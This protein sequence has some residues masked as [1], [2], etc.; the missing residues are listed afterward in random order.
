MAQKTGT[1]GVA[2]LLANLNTIGGVNSFSVDQIAQIIA[3]DNLNY[4]ALVTEAI[5]DLAETTEDQVRGSGGSAGGDMMEVDEFSRGPT[6]KD[7]PGYLIGFPLRKYQ[8]PLGWT[9]Q[10]ER[11]AT[12][13]DVAMKN[14]AAQAADMRRTRYEIQKAIF[15]PT[16]YSFRD[17]LVNKAITAL[18]VKAAI[19]ADS[20]PIPNGPNGEVFDGTT[21][22]HYDGAAALTAAA[23]QA[24]I[25]DV[26]EHRAG[27][28]IRVIINQAD[29]GS[30]QALAGFI[31]LQVPYVNINI[32]ANQANNARLD[33]TRMDNRQVG[34][35]GAAQV[36][37][38]PWGVQNYQITYDAAAPQKPL[39]RRV[40]K[41]PRGLF[42]AAEIDAHPLRAPYTENFYGFGAWNRTA[43]HVLRFNNAT[44]SAPALSF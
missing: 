29:L 15:T 4:S 16:N 23:V 39:V 10:W 28:D 17:F 42:V 43:L 14:A 27:A 40:E 5:A 41:N 18:P 30:Y 9:A 26:A 32:A 8:Y 37:T 13:N 25:N 11:N 24:A 7:V 22:T 1:Y 19:N 33:I 38:K 3:Q 20:T 31:P 44:Y 35:F 2:D 12:P 34:W 36:W 21:H 6:Q